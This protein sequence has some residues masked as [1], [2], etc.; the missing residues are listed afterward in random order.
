MLLTIYSVIDSELS[1]LCCP[2]D[3]SGLAFAGATNT[4]DMRQSEAVTVSLFFPPLHPQAI[5]PTTP[6][7]RHFVLSP[8]SLASTI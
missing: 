5:N 8:V 4:M 2:L 7:H 3:Q 6:T 1:T